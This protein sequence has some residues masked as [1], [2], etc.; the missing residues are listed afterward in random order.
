MGSLSKKSSANFKW[1]NRL[2]RRNGNIIV[3]GMNPTS[4]DVFGFRIVAD[5]LAGLVVPYYI[6]KDNLPAVDFKVDRELII[7]C[8]HVLYSFLRLLQVQ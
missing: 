3:S 2:V 7:L 8:F 4:N 6:R 5:V 1:R